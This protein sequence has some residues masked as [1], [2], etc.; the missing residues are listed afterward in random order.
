MSSRLPRLP[1]DLHHVS[2]L[3]SLHP[4]GRRHSSTTY[5]MLSQ[6]RSPP[7]SVVHSGLYSTRLVIRTFPR[8]ECDQYR[9]GL[10]SHWNQG[11]NVTGQLPIR[12]KYTLM[13]T[14]VREIIATILLHFTGLPDTCWPFAFPTFTLGTVIVYANSTVA[15]FSYT[16]LAL[17]VPWVHHLTAPFN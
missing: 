15:V 3:E 5:V 16:T 14:F 4:T 7:V 6:L 10:P 13:F 2:H 17:P 8:L 12:H 9:G 1:P 11:I